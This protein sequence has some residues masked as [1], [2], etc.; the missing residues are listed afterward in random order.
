MNDTSGRRDFLKL[1][2]AGLATAG[3]LTA[4]SAEKAAA[5][6]AP[7]SVLRTALDR[8]KLIVGT[9][10]TNAPWHF[11]NDAGELVGMDITMGRILAKGLFDDPTKV[12]FVTQD[13]AQRI[14]NVT[15]NKVD[16]TIQFMTMNAQ[17]SQL[18]HFSRPY[19][20]EGVAL[21]TLPGSENKT[22][23]KLLAG[24]SATRVSI[25]QNVDAETSV[26]YALPQAQVMQIDTQANVL[27][28]LESKR[29]DAAAVDLSTVR[30]L[31]S[32]NPDKYFDAGKSWYSMLYG[33]A[34][35]QGD[36]DWLTFVNQTFTIAMFGHETA[37]Y[38]AAFKE[39]FGQEP[40]LRHPGF[41]AV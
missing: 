39:Y 16:I 34:L 4:V 29:V 32:R 19:Y 23:D 24:G 18:I 2:M 14:P 13:P 30:W 20:V 15:T 25:L 5:Q 36:L 3:A 28:A 37:L 26:H 21:L 10:S 31:A 40:P 6:A 35:R 7:D 33:A 9:G 8:G 27:Q 17:R 1:G 22:F 41:P 38:D 11:E 12:E